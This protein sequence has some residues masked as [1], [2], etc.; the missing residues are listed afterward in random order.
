MFVL[1]VFPVMPPG[2]MVQLPDG[3]PF[4]TIPPVD[5]AQLGCVMVP[6]IIA[7]GVAFSLTCNIAGLFATQPK[8]LA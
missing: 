8:V 2:L 3:K 4:K 7:V 1:V 5:I 6:A